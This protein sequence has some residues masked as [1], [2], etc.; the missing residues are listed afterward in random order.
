[1]ND[2]LRVC[3]MHKTYTTGR[4]PT[5]VDSMGTGFDQMCVGA[6]G[7]T[8]RLMILITLAITGLPR[9][10][11]PWP[12]WLV[13]TTLSSTG[14]GLATSSWLRV[15]ALLLQLYGNLYLAVQFL[16][17]DVGHGDASHGLALPI[18]VNHGLVQKIDSRWSPLCDSGTFLNIFS[19]RL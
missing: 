12:S 10:N 8:C 9:V 3:T 7:K 13:L 19:M 11:F 17:I 15:E 5:K 18:V 14:F 16:E 2:V 4:R 1:M 6:T